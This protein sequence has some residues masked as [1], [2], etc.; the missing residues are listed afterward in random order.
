MQ[1]ASFQIKRFTR[2]KFLGYTTSLQQ[3]DPTCAPTKLEI[4]EFSCPILGNLWV[5]VLSG[6]LKWERAGLGGPTVNVPAL[7]GP[8]EGFPGHRSGHI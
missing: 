5:L 6:A 2:L 8:G 1:S 4:M 7:S 3:S